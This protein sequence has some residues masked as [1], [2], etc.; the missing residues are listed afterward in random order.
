MAFLLVPNEVR[1]D[2]AQVWVAAINETF[3]TNSA[4]IEFGGGSVPVPGW[5]NWATESGKFRIA[6]QRVLLT[7]LE[8]RRTYQLRLRVGDRVVSDGSVTTLPD[9]LP[10]I[11]ERPF[12]VLL[13][14]CFY[15]A[16]DKEGAVGRQYALLPEQPDIKL[17]CGD[18]VYLDNPPTDFINPL[19]SWS[20]LEDRSFKAYFDTWA[21][22]FTSG[23]FRELLKHGGNFFTSDDHE[24][25]NNA[26][27]VGLNVPLF[28]GRKSW[29]DRWL[30]I[31]RTLYRIFQTENSFTG[32]RVGPLS[33]CVLDTRI[34]R[35]P[36]RAALITAADLAGVRD[37]VAGLTGPGVIVLGQ[38][39]LAEE[40]D[41]KDW[42]L[43]AYPEYRQIVDLLKNS[44]HWIVVLTGDVH[45]GRMA[46]C[47]LRLDRGTRLIEIISSPMQLVPLAK[48]T[49]APATEV[50][51]PVTTEDNYWTDEKNHF[52]TLE[53]WAASAHRVQL[54]VKYW[55][56]DKAGTLPRAVP[57]LKHPI[58]LS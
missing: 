35:Q 2:V 38:A 1:A 27:D 18:Q 37:W 55:P 22:S 14:S 17:L 23:G 12:T 57:V 30:N 28:T 4:R 10:G 33:F 44:E 7:G 40:G 24:F 11:G 32:F 48:G 21:Q 9:R 26:P 54:N 58:E 36:D 34:N 41:K 43:R 6:Y 53:F 19:R 45:F 31:S 15:R 20:W 46:S 51:S 16:E 52:L 13:G 8:A 25:W 50:F 39:L 47:P 29:R 42:G 3:D 49:F 56:I 5:I